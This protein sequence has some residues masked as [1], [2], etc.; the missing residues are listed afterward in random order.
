L[1]CKWRPSDP[2][3]PHWYDE[4]RLARLIAA[5]IAHAEDHDRPCPTV[6]EF[7]SEFRGLSGTAKAKAICE[8]VGAPRKSLSEFY[9]DG[10]G[11]N[12]GSPFR[13]AEGQP[14]D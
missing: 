8:A 10:T 6:R 2:T 4:A 14:S 11:E 12:R 7:V 9:G 3:S 5:H 1:D 13:N